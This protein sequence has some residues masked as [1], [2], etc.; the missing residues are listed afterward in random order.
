[1]SIPSRPADFEALDACHRQIQLHLDKLAQL[2]ADF[3]ADGATSRSRELAGLI[4]SFF[5]KTAREHHLE[6]EKTVFPPLLSSDNEALVSAVRTLQQDHGWLEENWIV[7]G[8][9]LR[10]IADGYNWV[11][12]AEL[13]HNTELFGTLYGKHIALEEALIYPQSKQHWTEIL[14]QRTRDQSVS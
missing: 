6:E 1:M 9:Q 10:A 3:E 5:S 14:A 13:L 2:T 8:P 12:P 4:E 11:D 7:L